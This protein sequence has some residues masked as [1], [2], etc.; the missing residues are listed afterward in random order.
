M[1]IIEAVSVPAVASN[2]PTD[3]DDTP[4]AELSGDKYE[5]VN[6][7]AY[8]PG[9]LGWASKTQEG[10]FLHLLG[11]FNAQGR[12]KVRTDAIGIYIDC[13]VDV[14]AGCMG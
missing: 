3:D 6:P 5:L 8:I 2:E 10:L 12:T 9:N 7:P 11:L 1:L 4:L 14:S 13:H